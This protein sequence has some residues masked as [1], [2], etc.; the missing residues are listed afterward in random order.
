MN[1][2]VFN[3]CVF[4]LLQPVLVTLAIPSALSIPTLGFHDIFNTPAKFGVVF[5][6]VTT[7]FYVA[8]YDGGL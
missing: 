4:L 6:Y 1:C 7:A 8:T 3:D 5:G 2:W